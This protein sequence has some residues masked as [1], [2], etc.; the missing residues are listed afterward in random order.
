MTYRMEFECVWGMRVRLYLDRAH[1][2]LIATVDAL[3]LVELSFNS[4]L[5]VFPAV[6]LRAVLH[7]PNFPDSTSMTYWSMYAESSSNSLSE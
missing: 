2:V 7:F 3:R 6:A 1:H 4:S 5:L